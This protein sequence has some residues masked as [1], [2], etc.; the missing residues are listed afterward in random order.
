[1][2]LTRE[3]NGRQ[4]IKDHATAQNKVGK[5]VVFE[6][7]GWL[8]DAARLSNLGTVSNETRLEVLGEWQQASIDSKLAGDQFWQFGWSGWATGRNRKFP[9]WF[10]FFC[11]KGAVF[12]TLIL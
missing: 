2:I 1:L 8:T 11:G 3:L 7:Y 10:L 12:L 4:W 5:P 9:L 6:E